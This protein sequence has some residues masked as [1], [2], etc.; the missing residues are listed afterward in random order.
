MG[1]DTAM[2]RGS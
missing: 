2:G 1:V